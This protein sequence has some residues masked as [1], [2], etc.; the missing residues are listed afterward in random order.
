MS[1]LQAERLDYVFNIK[2]TA[3]LIVLASAP[4]KGGWGCLAARLAAFL[5]TC[6]LQ[7]VS[8]LEGI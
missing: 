7:K 5:Q 3:G 1:A 2:D 6:D 4:L 8:L